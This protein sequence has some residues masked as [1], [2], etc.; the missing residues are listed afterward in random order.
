[1]LTRARILILAV[2]LLP[3]AAAAQAD[4]SVG[5][6]ASSPTIVLRADVSASEVRFSRQPEIRVTLTGG[7]L[8]SVR[9]LERRN[10]PERVQPGVTYRDV[11]IAVEA[12]G[13][14]HA[15]CLAKQLAGTIS[16]RRAD[17]T[18]V[19]RCPA[20]TAAAPRVP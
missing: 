9:V 13:K 17:T 1:M 11:F 18:A 19:R 7:T 6:P 20:V 5:P 14:L 4:T 8:D 2:L 15:E 10:L 16:A 12:I 3:A